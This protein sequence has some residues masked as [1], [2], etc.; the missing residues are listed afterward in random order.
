MHTKTLVVD[1]ITPVGAYA[2]LRRDA[3]AGSFLLESV[4]P[5]E[6]WGRYSV[7]GYRPRSEVVVRAGQEDPFR[8]LARLVPT[9]GASE[10][11]VARRF[12]SS[13]VGMV[14]YDIVHYATK[15]D[16]WPDR[17]TLLDER[18]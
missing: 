11:D 17:G 2:A 15:V 1:G 6:R 8:Q 18:A 9:G 3:G 14:A 16:P 5:G 12:A 4:V 13:H 7:L 10:T